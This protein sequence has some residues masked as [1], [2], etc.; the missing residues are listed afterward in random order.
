MLEPNTQNEQIDPSARV[1]RVAEMERRLNEATAAVAALDAALEGYR[2]AQ[3]AIAELQDYYEDGRWMADFEADREGE[4]P[5]EL[6]H[7][8]LGEDAIYE[9]LTDRQRLREELRALAERAD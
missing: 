2:A 5:P 6:P 8:V 3:Q 7:G 1:A 9:L 4:L